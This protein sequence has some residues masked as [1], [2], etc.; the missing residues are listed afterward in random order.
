MKDLQ[1]VKL[2]LAKKKTTLNSLGDIP[3][4][5][6]VS[7]PPISHQVYYSHNL[8]IRTR[9]QKN[10]TVGN[11]DCVGMD[12]TPAVLSRASRVRR[13]KTVT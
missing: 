11:I 6:R 8:F 4:H 2:Y 7:R 1:P 13:Q 12:D 5:Y 3:P 9:G 10:T